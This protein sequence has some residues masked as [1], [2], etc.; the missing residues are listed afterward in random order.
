MSLK[1]RIRSDMKEAMKAKDK[2]RLSAIRLILAAIKKAEIDDPA[3]R[4]QLAA[5]SEDE[6]YVL[7][8]LHK[9][10]K[11]RQEA[12]TQYKAAQ[13]EDLAEKETADL[14][15]INEY[16]PPPL[17]E[18]SVNQLIQAAIQ[19]TQAQTIRDMG[20]VMAALKPQLEGRANMSQV[21]NKVKQQL[22]QNTA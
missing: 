9:L 22:N 13:R 3:I 15:V 4:E 12:I 10:A 17:S 5:G 2:P 6:S 19:Q 20:R 7:S 8:L 1:E 11:Q 18:E 21:S 14:D 16:L